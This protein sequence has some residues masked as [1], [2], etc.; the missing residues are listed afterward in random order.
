M[1]VPAAGNSE[2]PRLPRRLARRLRRWRER[3]EP[4]RPTK[5]SPGWPWATPG[6]PTPVPT[7]G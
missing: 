6:T 7:L 3:Q 1:P 2:R 4:D 5:L